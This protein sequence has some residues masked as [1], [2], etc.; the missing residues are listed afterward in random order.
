MRYR[1]QI[2]QK[3]NFC[4]FLS[5]KVEIKNTMLC[6]WDHT[7]VNIS[8]VGKEVILDQK[9]CGKSSAMF[10][11]KQTAIDNRLGNSNTILCIFATQG[12]AKLLEVKVRGPENSAGLFTL[13]SPFIK[14]ME[15]WG[16]PCP[17][18]F[19]LVK[20][21]AA[22]WRCFLVSK[23]PYFHSTYLFI[24]VLPQW[25][26]TVWAF[27]SKQLMSPKFC[28]LNAHYWSLFRMNINMVQV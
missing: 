16:W 5:P 21:V 14:Q 25:Q 18:G 22:L 7:P 20:S 8:T 6:D 13:A 28:H 15:V 4:F 3:I 19:C 27:E 26:S 2:S 23:Y 11:T 17:V 9:T 1:P 10:F 12:A 24:G